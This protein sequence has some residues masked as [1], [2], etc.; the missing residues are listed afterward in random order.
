M[1]EKTKKL[2]NFL[3]Y[4][5]LKGVKDLLPKQ[6]R[7]YFARALMLEATEILKEI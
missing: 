1:L 2:P 5:N 3:T 6:A 4:Y 7:M